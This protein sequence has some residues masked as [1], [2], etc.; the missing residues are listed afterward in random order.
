MA[1]EGVVRLQFRLRRWIFAVC[2]VALALAALGASRLRFDFSPQNLFVS[3]DPEYLYLRKIH[4]V[5]GR[6]DNRLAVHVRARQ[7]F[8]PPT[9]SW[10]RALHERLAAI[11]GVERVDDLTTVVT[12]EPGRLGPTPLLPAEEGAD[13]AVSRR[14]AL[15][16]P[17]VRGRLV[18]EHARATLVSVRVADERMGYQE[19]RPVVGG[20]VAALE[21][22]AAPP[23]LEAGIVG[24]PLARVVLV[25]RLIADQLTFMPLCVVLFATVLWLLFR[26]L[27]AVFVPLGAVLVSLFLTLGWMGG[28]G[29]SIDIIN[30]VLPTLL[31]VIGVSD[32]IH[33]VA[34]YRQ[35][36]ADG[37]ERWP[38][39]RETCVHLGV[40]CLLTSVTT[41]VGLASLGLGRLE[42]LRRFGLYAAGGVLI[43]Y[44]VTVWLVPLVLSDLRPLVG[45]ASRRVS[46]YAETWALRTARFTQRRR[47]EIVAGGLA[48]T[49]AAAVAARGVE[50][51]NRIFESFPADDPLVEANRRFEEDFPGIIPLSVVVAWDEGTDILA[52]AVLEYLQVLGRFLDA[53]PLVGGVAS[54]VQ[55]IEEGNVLLHAGDPAW[56][57][58]PQTSAESRRILGVLEAGLT[59][60]GRQE[61]LA[62]LYRPGERLL[63]L[64]AQ[65][66]DIGSRRLG[67]LV[68]SIEGRLEADQ[69]RHQ[70]LG[71]RVELSGDGPVGSA[72][73]DRLIGDMLRSVLVAFLV[74]FAVMIP[75]L[76]SLRAAIVSMLPNVFPLLLTLGVLGVVGLEL[77]VPTIIVFSVALGLAVD[78]TIHFMVRF[79]EEWRREADY[80]TAMERTFRG[81]GLA[82]FT[83]SILLATGFSILLLSRFPITQKFGLG[84]LL[85]VLAALVGD[86]LVLPACLA[87]F[88]PFRSRRPSVF[89][90]QQE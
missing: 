19:L 16:H 43:A 80:S 6:D 24:I 52:P 55:L 21:G 54:P 69:A 68:E 84:M 40:A 85:I 14:R 17:L 86:L 73:I 51:E 3:G 63:R 45:A 39:L 31:F 66:G 81:T 59:A 76:R 46:G 33:L 83:T 67:E 75:A 53:L 60:A 36:L 27:R 37:R 15:E 48:L 35:E 2:A 10:L 56:R 87:V 44:V 89:S 64:T 22:L 32:A 57:R 78:D 38:A 1:I 18:S 58:L 50:V 79:R 28:T 88:R 11:P 71:I 47:Y 25:R 4:S 12:A 5:F 70:A 49:I 90:R 72:A 7:L 13:L 23:G 62:D 34:R 41:A 20:I 9:I 8:S 42:V 61:L 29:G 82:I 74:I 30:N 65:V 77:Q 26:D